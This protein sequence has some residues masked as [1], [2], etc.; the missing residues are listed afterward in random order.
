M[1]E[2][3]GKPKVNYVTVFE[4]PGLEEFL[5]EVSEFANLVLF[6]AGLEGWLLLIIFRLPSHMY[7]S[8]LLFYEWYLYEFSQV[9]LDRLL[10]E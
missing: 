3:E 2:C 5:K 9:M 8:P 4:R 1:K 10:T 6:T 7:F